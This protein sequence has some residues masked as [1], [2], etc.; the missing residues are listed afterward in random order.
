MLNF[1]GANSIR[2]AVKIQRVCKELAKINNTKHVLVTV[3]FTDCKSL[4]IVSVM[5]MGI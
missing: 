2:N 1:N 4:W 3:L 5:L